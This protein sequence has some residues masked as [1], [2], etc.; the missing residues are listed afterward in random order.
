MFEGEIRLQK[1]FLGF[2]P[3]SRNSFEPVGKS[4][5][6]GSRSDIMFCSLQPC[7]V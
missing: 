1:V 7:S 4:L 5:E 2:R 6:K 3:A